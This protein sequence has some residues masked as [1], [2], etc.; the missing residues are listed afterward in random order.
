MPDI[1]GL[2]FDP[3]RAFK[4][5]RAI[6]DDAILDAWGSTRSKW[7]RLEESSTVEMGNDRAENGNNSLRP[8][9][10]RDADVLRADVQISSNVKSQA[11]QPSNQE[12]RDTWQLPGRRLPSRKKTGRGESRLRRPAIMAGYL[13]SL[14]RRSVGEFVTR[15]RGEKYVRGLGLT[16]AEEDE[17]PGR[18]ERNEGTSLR[19]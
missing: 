2:G 11:G 19:S 12:G 3:G 16:T 15:P 14:R 17:A 4:S 1:G 9:E 5:F 10:S 6:A 8:C 18:I 13:A 7:L